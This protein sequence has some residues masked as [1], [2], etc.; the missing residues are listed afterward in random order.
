MSRKRGANTGA[1]FIFIK[2][3]PTYVY[4]CNCTYHGTHR[5]ATT[6]QVKKMY[7]PKNFKLS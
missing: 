2:Y 4:V 7:M 5:V 1:F 6:Y 3:L